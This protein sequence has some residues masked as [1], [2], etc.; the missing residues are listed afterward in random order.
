VLPT[1][2]ALSFY[3][4]QFRASTGLLSPWTTLTSILGLVGLVTLMYQLRQRQRLVALGIGFYIGCHL[5]TGTVLPLELAYEHRNYF[6]SLGL[7]LALVPLLLEMPSSGA[8]TGQKQRGPLAL[9][10]VILLACLMLWWTYL[11]AITAWAWGDPLRLAQELGAR[12]PDSPRAQ[13]ELGRTYII[14]SHYDPASPYTHMAYAPL[15]RAAALPDSSIL[16]EQALIFMNARMQLP[17]K[18]AWWDSMVSKLKTRELGVQDE[19]SLQALTTCIRDHDCNLS[20]DRMTEAYTAALS[21]PNPSARL[22]SMYGDFEWNIVQDHE[23]GMRATKEA[24]RRA[25]NEPAYRITLI[26]MLLVSGRRAE[27]LQQLEYLKQL[28][29]GGRLDADIKSLPL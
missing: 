20:T 17:I 11:T 24:T 13:Y 25:P 21:H 6:A 12:A 8:R 9:P 2:G 5:L 28:N 10:R 7:L 19:S 15:E 29:I 26:R 23:L 1:S 14:Y 3:H 4:D 22:L 27:A 18:D 16:P